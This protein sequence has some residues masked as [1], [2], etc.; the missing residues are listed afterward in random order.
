M[1]LNSSDFWTSFHQT[2]PRQMEEQ[3]YDPFYDPSL[4]PLIENPNMNPKAWR[5][6]CHRA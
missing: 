1:N 3:K 4:R 2:F 5:T 6:S